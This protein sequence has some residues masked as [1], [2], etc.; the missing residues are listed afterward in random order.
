MKMS[1]FESPNGNQGEGAGFDRA[2][3]LQQI[4]RTQ[5]ALRGNRPTQ[6]DADLSAK[7]SE[8]TMRILEAGGASGVTLQRRIQ[9]FASVTLLELQIGKK[10]EPE[11]LA[12]FLE[13]T[14]GLASADSLTRDDWSALN[15]ARTRM[16][17]LVADPKWSMVHGGHIAMTCLTLL[18]LYDVSILNM[19]YSG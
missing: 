6:K 11:Q 7:F 18:S 15:A 17:A 8:E 14:M 12:P 10:P 5:F 9:L 16:S 1:G 13:S 19:S 3:S 2:F 4:I